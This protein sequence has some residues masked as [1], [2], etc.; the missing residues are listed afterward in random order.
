M[1][2]TKILR[3]FDFRSAAGTMLRG[4]NI[5]KGVSHTPNPMGINTQ[6]IAKLALRKRKVL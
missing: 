5:Y 3:P 2:T 6:K 4:K 1:K